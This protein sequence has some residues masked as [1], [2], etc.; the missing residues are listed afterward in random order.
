MQD[1]VNFHV[2]AFDREIDAV[3]AGAAA[4]KLALPPLEHAEA[5]GQAVL[6]NVIR[7]NI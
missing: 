7:L 5:L 4:E 3:L 2:D 1:P 6:L